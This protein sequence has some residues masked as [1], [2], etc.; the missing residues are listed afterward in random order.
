MKD[1]EIKALEYRK[2]GL[3]SRKICEKLGWRKS[4]KS[5]INDMFTRYDREQQA[6]QQL[7]DESA[8]KKLKILY[9][10][11]E[12]SPEEGYVWG[13]WKQNLSEEMIKRHSHLLSVAYAYNDGPVV[14]YKM[15][16]E[17]IDQE[18]DL[19]LVVNLAKAINEADLLVSFNGVKFDIKYLRTRMLYWGL[20]PLKPIK[21]LDLYLQAKSLF[22]FPSNSMQNICKYLGFSILKQDTGGFGLWKRCMMTEHYQQSINALDQMCE[23]NR[24]DIEVTR[25]LHKKVMSWTTGINIGTLLNVKYNT[26]H[27]RCTKCGSQDVRKEEGFDYTAQN[28]FELYRCNDCNGVSRINSKG[29]KLLGVSR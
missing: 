6:V 15:T 29:D 17:E 3:S 16:P 12:T 7:L 19:T 5:T 14:G 22:R 4:Q 28:G 23:Y 10:D 18:D 2:D 26:D 20:P 11:I 21:H 24:G 8:E 9:F 1:W 13:R 25:E 27:L